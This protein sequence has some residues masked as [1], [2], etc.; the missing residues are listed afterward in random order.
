[1][2][3]TYKNTFFAIASHPFLP[4]KDGTFTFISRKADEPKD[5]VIPLFDNHDYEKGE[6]GFAIIHYIPCYKL[7]DGRSL[8]MCFAQIH[9]DAGL[10]IGQGV[11]I[12]FGEIA[13]RGHVKYGDGVCELS[14]AD[15][16]STPL[17]NIC[18]PDYVSEFVNS[19]HTNKFIIPNFAKL[20]STIGEQVWRNESLKKIYMAHTI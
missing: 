17:C 2:N 18:K 1:M 10:I 15:M 13:R 11:S 12:G 20:L 8:S 14:I 5:E 19:I 3:K 9:T 7:I 6:I 16:P 4:A